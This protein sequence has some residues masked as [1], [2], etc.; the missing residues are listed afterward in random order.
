M[1]KM[2]YI[3]PLD[4]EM[5]DKV[6]NSSLVKGFLGTI[7]DEHLDDINVYVHS[8]S[9]YQLDNHPAVEYL[10]EGC[11]LFG[12]DEQPPVYVVRS[13]QYDV[14]CTGY[15][16]PVIQIPDIFLENADNDILR[17]RMMA[18]AAAVKAGHHKLKFLLWT[19]QN[20]GSIIP[21]PF[22]TTAMRGL[23]YEWYRAQYYTYDRAF[24]LS[25]KNMELSLKNILFG[26][27]S[28]DILENFEFG[29][30]DTYDSQVESFFKSNNIVEG[31]ASIN[32]FFQHE[33]W[34]PARYR[35]LKK[36]CK[37]DL[38]W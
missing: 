37:G 11:K 32:A 22:A 14:I 28:P 19:L 34:L 25:T 21:I 15:E 20:F 27:I 38:A 13:Y 9:L 10:R 4:R 26:E 33:S 8:A 6:L 23:L 12:V 36:Y 18:M 2:D 30:N 16:K 17:G 1:T 31:L 7:F 29:D 35:E 3:H 5:A 24:Y